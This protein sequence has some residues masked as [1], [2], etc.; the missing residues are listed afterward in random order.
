MLSYAQP[1]SN[2]RN[3]SL[4]K[5]LQSSSTDHTMRSPLLFLLIAVSFLS[6]DGMQTIGTGYSGYC[7]CLNH[8]HRLIPANSLRSIEILPRGP[9]CKTTE[10]IATMI[11]GQRICLD[12]HAQWVK[13]VVRFIKEKQ[14]QKGNLV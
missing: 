7:K 10:V 3:S 13:K 2:E 5:Q 6:T 1:H 8:E 11:S 12:R 14:R 4:E 9:S